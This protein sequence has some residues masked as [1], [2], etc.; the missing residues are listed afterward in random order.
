MYL[1]P[2][3][4]LRG[5]VWGTRHACF[6][7]FRITFPLRGGRGAAEETF[8]VTFPGQRVYFRGTRVVWSSPG[9]RYVLD[10]FSGTV[11][12]RRGRFVGVF[13]DGLTTRGT[14]VLN[15]K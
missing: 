15:R 8:T 2:T 13:H 1:N 4:I 11:D 14:V 3:H 9:S 10:R 7:R 12:Y 5:K 6:G